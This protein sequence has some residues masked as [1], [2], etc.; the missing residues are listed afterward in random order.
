MFRRMMTK[1]MKDGIRGDRH[2]GQHELIV[3]VLPGIQLGNAYHD[4]AH[5]GRA[6][7]DDQRPEIGVPDRDEA[8]H[9]K[10][11]DDRLADGHQDRK[12]IPQIAAAVDHGSIAQILRNGKEFLPEHEHLAGADKAGDAHA[13]IGVE[14]P[15]P[16]HGHIVGDEE[17]VAGHHRC[18][19]NEEKQKFFPRNS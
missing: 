2:A 9:E 8:L 3:G 14:Q 5:I 18:A 17:R 12:N 6:G 10:R 11:R 4:G 7:G 15:Q 1:R 16:G 13:E 19:E